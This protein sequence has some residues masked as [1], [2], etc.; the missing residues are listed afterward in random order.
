MISGI[1]AS[2]GI[3]FGKVLLFEEKKIAVKYKKVS[4]ET[5]NQEK[6]KKKW[7]HTVT[8]IPDLSKTKIS[9]TEIIVPRKNSP[10]DFWEFY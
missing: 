5:I 1:L 2:P 3:A 7:K 6:S 9:V 10:R 8:T 4:H